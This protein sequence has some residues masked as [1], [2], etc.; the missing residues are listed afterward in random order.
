MGVFAA[1]EAETLPLPPTPLVLARWST[2]TVGP[3]LHSEGWPRPLL[4]AHYSGKHKT[5]G[6]LLLALTDERG[7]LIR[8]SSARDGRFSEVT[9]ARRDRHRAPPRGRPRHPGR[10]RPRRPGRDPP[11]D[12]PVSVT[13]RRAARNHRLTHA[14]KEANRLL[15]RE[16]AAVES[17][18]S[19]TSDLTHDH[20]GLRER[21]LRNRPPA[22]PPR[23]RERRSHSNS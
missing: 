5:H 13:G 20:H 15:S 19:P 3:D 10:P 7:N 1:L 18:A 21:P 2:A 17:T 14:E 8:T 4:G 11:D 9:A 23:P 6:Q 16:R 22:G 12:D